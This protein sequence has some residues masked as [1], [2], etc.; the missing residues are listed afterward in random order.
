VESFKKLSSLP[1]V[2][3]IVTNR[4]L[5]GSLFF[6]HQTEITLLGG[7]IAIPNRVWFFAR[8]KELFLAS[9]LNKEEVVFW[10]FCQKKRT[11]NVNDWYLVLR[12][13]DKHL[14]S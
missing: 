11:D 3:N 1:S 2:E 5:D 6:D 4:S 12:K 14:F 13:K 10:F 8:N 7:I 9:S